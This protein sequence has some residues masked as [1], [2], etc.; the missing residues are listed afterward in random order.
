MPKNPVK[1]KKGENDNEDSFNEKSFSEYLK[2]LGAERESVTDKSIQLVMDKL[3]ST[4][5]NDLNKFTVLKNHDHV[6]KLFK[7]EMLN[8][9]YIKKYLMSEKEYLA[10]NP[11][12]RLI[13]IYKELNISSDDGRGRK[14]VKEV[15]TGLPAEPIPQEGL[16]NRVKHGIGGL[17]TKRE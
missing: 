9:L 13:Q 10:Y 11:H 12:E 4:S 17:L 2:N 6:V 5:P 1:T 16:L 3:A 7:M 14:D 8:E 15:I